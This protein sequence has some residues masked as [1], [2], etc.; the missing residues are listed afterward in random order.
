MLY[1]SHMIRTQVYLPKALYHNLQL[2]AEH[3][4][5]PAAEIIRNLL[6]RG[7][8][9]LRRKQNAGEALLFLGKKTTRDVAVQTGQL[10]MRSK[11]FPIVEANPDIR[12]AALK[13]YGEQRGEASF[14]DSMVMAFVDSYGAQAIF[15]FD[16][17]FKSSG[18][19]LLDA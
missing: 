10:L 11:A 19:T 4:Q 17:H 14:T 12:A 7:L 6:E 1:I 2:V 15:G 16:K 8:S 5:K 18:Y 13:K 3:E 9:Q